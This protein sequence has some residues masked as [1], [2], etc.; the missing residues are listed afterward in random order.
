MSEITRAELQAA[1]RFISVASE[2]FAEVARAGADLPR[3]SAT[4]GALM[5]SFVHA[6]VPRGMEMDFVGHAVETAAA[7]LRDHGHEGCEVL[8][9]I[10]DPEPGEGEVRH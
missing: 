7:F 5:G 4:F 6:C 8:V 1:M 2:A 9:G 10:A 3:L